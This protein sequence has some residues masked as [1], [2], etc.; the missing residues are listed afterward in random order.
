MPIAVRH[1][2]DVSPDL[3]PLPGLIVS[4]EAGPEVMA[5]LQNK[6]SQEM[7]QRFADGHRAYIA[8]KAGEPVAWGWVATRTARIGELEFTFPIATA[9]RYLWNFVTLSA[10]RG[11]GIYSRLLDAIVRAELTDA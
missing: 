6:S 3:T 2:G 8:W 7:A 5:K 9:D 11:M 4:L 10:H 1:R